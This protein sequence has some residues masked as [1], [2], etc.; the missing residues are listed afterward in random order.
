MADSEAVSDRP[1]FFADDSRRVVR[2][3]VPAV[4]RP[5]MGHSNLDPAVMNGVPGTL[6]SMSGQSAR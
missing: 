1:T 5:V 6:A 3:A 4:G 2:A